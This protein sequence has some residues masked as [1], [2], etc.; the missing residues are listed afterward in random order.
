MKQLAKAG[1]VEVTGL[2]KDVRPYLAAATVVVA[3]LRVGGGTRLKILE[4][5][6]MGK[7]TVSTSLGAEGIAIVPG[8]D[9][10]IAD[11]PQDF[12]R[13]VVKVLHHEGEQKRLGAAGRNL[14]RRHYDWKAIAQRLETIYQECL[15]GIVESHEFAR[16][17]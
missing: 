11:A 14:A 2:V 4:A 6:A 8:E 10:L 5:L 1:H 15:E 3:P 12:A 16:E 7:A 17:G 9:V 13:K